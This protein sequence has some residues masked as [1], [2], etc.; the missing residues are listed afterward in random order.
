MPYAGYSI[1]YQ[2]PGIIY[3]LLLYNAYLLKYVAMILYNPPTGW[4]MAT[5]WWHCTGVVNAPW[6]VETADVQKG[7]MPSCMF[8]QENNTWCILSLPSSFSQVCLFRCIWFAGLWMLCLS[9][10]VRWHGVALFYLLLLRCVHLHQLCRSLWLTEL[11][12][13]AWKIS[14]DT[15]CAGHS[16]VHRTVVVHGV[17]MWSTHYVVAAQGVLLQIVVSTITAIPSVWYLGYYSQDQVGSTCPLARQQQRELLLQR[18]RRVELTHMSCHLYVQYILTHPPEDF[19][20]FFL[21][22]Y[23]SSFKCS[24]IWTDFAALR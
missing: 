19:F 16:R 14:T 23:F 6:N 11:V 3:L 17:I 12:S 7:N 4:L 22:G 18:E 1:L 9:H 15:G 20:F 24:N 10:P 5:A 8:V 13:L 21:N 2:V